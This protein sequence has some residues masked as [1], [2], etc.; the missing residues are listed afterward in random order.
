MASRKLQKVGRLAEA[1]VRQY[2]RRIVALKYAAEVLSEDP[3]FAMTLAEAL[4]D[5]R[6][7]SRKWV[8]CSVKNLS[9]SFDRALCRK[10]RR[11]KDVGTEP[12]DR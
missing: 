8:R 3:Q 2:E 11:N 4:T 5:D 7:E 12:R 9:G 1:L 10:Y 6:L